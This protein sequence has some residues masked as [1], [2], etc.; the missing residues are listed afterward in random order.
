MFRLLHVYTTYTPYVARHAHGVSAFIV[1][2]YLFKS[3]IGTP[4][5]LR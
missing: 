2:R 4:N 3:T 5:D 1:G